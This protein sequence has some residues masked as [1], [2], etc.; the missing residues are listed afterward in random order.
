MKKIVKGDEGL[1]ELKG[2][3]ENIT[4]DN[5]LYEEYSKSKLYA[6]EERREG[7]K[8]GKEEEKIEIAKKLL[9]NNVDIDIISS[10]TGLKKEDIINLK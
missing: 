1:M 8:E 4:N 5:D 7:K 9:N 2:I 6:M 10:S 3:I